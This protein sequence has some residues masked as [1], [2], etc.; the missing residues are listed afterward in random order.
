MNNDNHILPSSI[1]KS[2]L[3][4]ESKTDKA[5]LQTEIILKRTFGINENLIVLH[6]KQT[7]VFLHTIL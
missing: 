2:L 4:R 7:L 6:L 3:S 1:K 5:V